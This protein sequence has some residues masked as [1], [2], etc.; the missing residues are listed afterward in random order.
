MVVVRGGVSERR[1]SELQAFY[2]LSFVGKDNTRRGFHGR[3]RKSL[4]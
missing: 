2:S 4:R 1:A 3:P